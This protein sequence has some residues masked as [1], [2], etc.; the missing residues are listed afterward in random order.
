[1]FQ[2]DYNKAQSRGKY[3]LV[4][5]LDHF[6]SSTVTDPLSALS[7]WEI[8]AETKIRPPSSGTRSIL[9]YKELTNDEVMLA[10]E[11]GNKFPMWS[12]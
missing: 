2:V 3:W 12:E 1:M 9:F 7:P 8:I 6:D 11:A 10:I 4:T 5:Y